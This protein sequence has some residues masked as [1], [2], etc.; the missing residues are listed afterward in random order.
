MG[1]SPLAASIQVGH[2]SVLL[3]SL[4]HMLPARRNIPG[5]QNPKESEETI[6]VSISPQPTSNIPVSAPNAAGRM[7]C[8][9][10]GQGIQRQEY[11]A[12]PAGIATSTV[13]M[14]RRIRFLR[15]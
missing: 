9:S 14:L 8:A 1:P 5:E 13:R 3:V 6:Q 10:S 11:S 2:G 4:S 15:V 7:R 12:H